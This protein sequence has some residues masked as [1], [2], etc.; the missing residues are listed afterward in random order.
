MVLATKESQV[1][2][3]IA[4]KTFDIANSRNRIIQ[5]LFSRPYLSNDRAYGRPT[6]TPM[7]SGPRGRRSPWRPKLF[8]IP[9]LVLWL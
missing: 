1:R 4:R 3:N 9:V 2:N 5:L 6:P 8:F 7:A